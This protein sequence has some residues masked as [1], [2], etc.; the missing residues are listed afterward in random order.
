MA[1][2]LTVRQREVLQFIMDFK[3]AHEMP[4]TRAEIAQYFGFKVHNGAY[5]HVLALVRKGYLEVA[6]RRARGIRVLKELS[7]L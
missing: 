6:S 2:E 1:K 3:R 7:P 4:P 5:E